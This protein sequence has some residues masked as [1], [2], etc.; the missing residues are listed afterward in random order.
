MCGNLKPTSSKDI[1]LKSWHTPELWPL[2]LQPRRHSKSPKKKGR[3]VLKLNFWVGLNK[4]QQIARKN[5]SRCPPCLLYD[6][7]HV[8]QQAWMQ[9]ISLQHSQL[10]RQCCPKPLTLERSVCCV[11]IDDAP[12][13]RKIHTGRLT[14]SRS[15]MTGKVHRN[16]S[17]IGNTT[18]KQQIVGSIWWNCQPMPQSWVSGPLEEC[19]TNNPGNLWTGDKYMLVCDC[20]CMYIYIYIHICAR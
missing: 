16:A 18:T 10:K 2:G 17:K 8:P 6:S 4:L 12:T 20:A 1:W 14:T 19:L 13:K 5:S 15:R 9:R 11:K 3:Q 7:Y